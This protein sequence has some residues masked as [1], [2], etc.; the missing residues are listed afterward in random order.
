[1]TVNWTLYANE[2][3]VVHYEDVK[4]AELRRILT[5]LDLPVDEERLACIEVSNK[6]RRAKNTASFS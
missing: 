2:L 1:M 5:F 4:E 6:M 3:L